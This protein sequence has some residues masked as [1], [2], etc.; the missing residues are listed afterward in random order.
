MLKNLSQ[1][2][3][4]NESHKKNGYTMSA[5]MNKDII[6]KEENN[7]KNKLINPKYI[8]QKK[9][10]NYKNTNSTTYRSPNENNKMPTIKETGY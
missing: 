9:P 1:I 7:N 8:F 3:E 5:K 4:I 10:K 2:D 6:K